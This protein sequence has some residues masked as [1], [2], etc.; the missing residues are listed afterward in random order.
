M[1]EF[2]EVTYGTMGKGFHNRNIGDPKADVALNSPTQRGWELTKDGSLELYAQHA[3]KSTIRLQALQSRSRRPGSASALIPR[4][5]QRS[6]AIQALGWVVGSVT[7]QRLSALGSRQ[8]TLQLFMGPMWPPLHFFLLVL[9]ACIQS[10]RFHYGFSQHTLFL[11]PFLTPST[12]PAASFLLA[13]CL[14]S[15]NAFFSIPYLQSLSIPQ[16]E[17]AIFVFLL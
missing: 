17:H 1:N 6:V 15:N 4:R 11:S 14:P 9:K 7:R 16:R 8:Y 10:N 3:R 2:V 12:T 5:E 13:H